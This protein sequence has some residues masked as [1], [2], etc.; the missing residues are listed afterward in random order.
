LADVSPD[1]CVADYWLDAM[2]SED[3]INRVLSVWNSRSGTERSRAYQVFQLKWGANEA[4]I[5]KAFRV[6]AL[7]LHPDKCSSERAPDAMMAIN[8]CKELLEES[9]KPAGYRPREPYQ[10]TRTRCVVAL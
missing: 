1:E 6:L 5:K 4:E 9:A 8:K 7:R 3:L 2:D 10:P